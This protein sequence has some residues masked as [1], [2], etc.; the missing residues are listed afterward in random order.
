[1]IIGGMSVTRSQNRAKNVQDA[2]P[3]VAA[4]VPPQLIL[5]KRSHE[6]SVAARTKQ[7]YERDVP[8]RNIG[9]VF[10]YDGYNL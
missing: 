9:Q 10:S 6:L 4:S 1:M 7:I 8:T 2:D 5:L 3:D